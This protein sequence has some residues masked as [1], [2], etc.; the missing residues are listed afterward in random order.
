VPGREY[1]GSGL[2]GHTEVV[3]ALEQLDARPVVGGLHRLAGDRRVGDALAHDVLALQ[4][5]CAIDSAKRDGNSATPIHS[6]AK[7]RRRGRRKNK[8]IVAIAP[9]VMSASSRT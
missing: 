2:S 6:T 4:L 7:V 3:P 1:R 5:E 8:G 9:A